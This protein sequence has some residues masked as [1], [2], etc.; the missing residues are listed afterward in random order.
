MSRLFRVAVIVGIAVLV[1][2]ACGQIQSS[3]PVGIVVMKVGGE[4]L[5][6]GVQNV[7]PHIDFTLSSSP[8]PTAGVS[9]LIDGNPLQVEYGK[10][11]INAEARKEFPF[12]STHLLTVR[13]PGIGT[14]EF[15]FTV[16]STTSCLLAWFKDATGVK[17]IDIS[18]S[19]APVQ[20][21]LG[22]YLPSG[23]ISW[24][25][26]TEV[27]VHP[28]SSLLTLRLPSS[29]PTAHGAHLSA[30]LVRTLSSW[31][32]LPQLA[33]DP[34]LPATPSMT[35]TAFS[36]GES[37][38][39]ASLVHY[40]SDIQVLDPVGL[41]LGANGSIVGTVSDTEISTAQANHLNVMPVIQNSF[42]D[43]TGIVTLL[44]SKSLVAQFIEQARAR[45][46]SAGYSGVNIDFENIPSSLR[47]AY[48]TF[49]GELTSTFH[50]AGKKVSVDVPVSTLGSPNTA[51]DDAAISHEADAVIVMA[52]DENTSPGSPGPVAGETW[53]AETLAG[54]LPGMV[55]SHVVLGM[56][57]YGRVWEGTSVH[58]CS[59]AQCEEEVMMLPH[60][61]VTEDF[62][63]PSVL[64]TATDASGSTVTAAVS[65]QE[66]VAAAVGIAVQDHLAGVAVWR[67][68]EELP[69]LTLP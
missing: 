1:L 35:L 34:A 19:N 43:P 15:H 58:A 36:T 39:L 7:P 13:I 31:T 67:L 26:P 9:V 33:W 8:E 60:A 50:A 4:L 16:V 52:Y 63:D 14:E 29:L 18:F 32:Q 38:S 55:P 27:V 64:V 23:S 54:M 10:S 22:R 59:S 45:V 53:V 42:S 69:G 37:D 57:L 56:P 25:S 62:A 47:S 40:E 49:I 24:R 20:S 3:Q 46:L 51:Y 30:T 44:G 41:Y 61:F 12:G 65:T 17:T 2:P 5:S 11:I 21:A 6:D 28:S 66:T 48:T 68:G